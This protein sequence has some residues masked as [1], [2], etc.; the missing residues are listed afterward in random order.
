MAVEERTLPS[1]DAFI[2]LARTRRSIRGYDPTR[3]VPDAVIEQLIEAARWAPSGGNGQPW[4]FV[5]IR[6]AADRAWNVELFLKQQEHKAEMERAARGQVRLTGAGFKNAP[7]HILV[8]GD[9]RVNES[10]PIRTKLEKSARHFY[11]GLAC[12]TLS[13][14]FAARCLGLAT[15]YV[16]DAGSPY[17]GTLLKVRYGIPDPLEVYELVPVGYPS[18]DVAPTPRRPL[19][20]MIHRGR[21]EAD[22]LLSDAEMK[23]WLWKDSRLGAYGKGP[24][25]GAIQAGA[26]D[27]E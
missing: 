19:A 1:L 10:Y 5:V 14:M 7:V 23:R 13:L 8:V 16:S 22:K 27:A 4:H 18:S 21:F 2:A 26:A 6:D 12:A 11:S 3:D 9:P 20:S 25:Q 15:Q 17:M 24:S